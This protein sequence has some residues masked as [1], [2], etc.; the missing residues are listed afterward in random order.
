MTYIK[1]KG[2]DLMK[3]F[4]S[5]PQMHYSWAWKSGLNRSVVCRYNWGTQCTLVLFWTSQYL[6]SL[7]AEVLVSRKPSLDS[8]LRLLKCWVYVFVSQKGRDELGKL[9]LLSF[10]CWPFSHQ[11]LGT[12]SSFHCKKLKQG[13]GSLWIPFHHL[14]WDE[15]NFLVK[16]SCTSDFSE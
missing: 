3:R 16:T 9:F 10:T 15:R 13:L 12:N 4:I 5:V 6:P 7:S 2:N 11:L 1:L 8:Y 14:F